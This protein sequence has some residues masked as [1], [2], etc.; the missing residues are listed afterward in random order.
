MKKTVLTL[1]ILLLITGMFSL[2][3]S[4]FCVEGSGNVSEGSRE[5]FEFKQIEADGIGTIHLIKGDTHHV[6]IEADDNILPLIK[7]GINDGVLEISNEKCIN[8][9][10]KLDLYITY[11]D[12]ERIVISGAVKVTSFENLTTEKLYLEANGS[13]D[14]DLAID[15]QQL[16]TDLKGSGSILLRG[17]AI[18]H[19]AEVHGSGNLDA[20]RLINNEL[21]VYVTGSGNCMVFVLTKLRAEAS[22][23]GKI[24][25]KG[26]PK[27]VK[28]DA[29]GSG[30]IESVN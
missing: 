21:E 23:S 9:A 26:S 16:E 3:C 5:L 8:N 18:E 4:M 24:K 6:R 10:T 13:G 25:Y 19:E 2:S 29:K 11:T 12:I 15:V 30:K 20:Y 28:T 7:T 27:D 1:V 22:G 17:K 14:I